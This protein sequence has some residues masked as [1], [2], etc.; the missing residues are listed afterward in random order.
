MGRS[1]ELVQTAVPQPKKKNTFKNHLSIKILDV[2]K[3]IS[4]MLNFWSLPLC[5]VGLHD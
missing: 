5:R 1:T 4:I 2:Y 3:D